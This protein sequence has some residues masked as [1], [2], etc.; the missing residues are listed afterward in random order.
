[1]KTVLWVLVVVCLVGLLA[2]TNPDMDRYQAYCSQEIQQEV[3]KKG[4]DPLTGALGSLLGGFAGTVMA[5]QT[6]R[7]DYVI[8]SSYDT[9]LG[10]EHFRAIGVLNNFIV[11]EKPQRQSP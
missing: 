10:T 4:S 7:H 3:G 5:S 1:M 9:T 8:F 6:A 11:L 2:Y